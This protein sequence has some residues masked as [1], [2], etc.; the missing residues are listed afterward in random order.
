M[1]ILT[2]S[3]LE[4]RVL[5]KETHFI[6]VNRENGGSSLKAF[7]NIVCIVAGTGILG[8]PTAL[9]QGGWIGLF[10]IFL[11]WWMSS[12]TSIILIR[13]LYTNQKYRMN[14]YKDVA[15]AAFGT[16]GE[17][18]SFAGNSVL[19][20]GIPVLYIVLGGNNLNE[21]CRGTVGE[22][23]TL[24]W[25][26]VCCGIVAIPILRFKSLKEMSLLTSVGFINIVAVSIIVLV[27]ACLD[28]PNQVD[29]HRE[30]V[31]WDMFPIAFSTIAFSFGGNVIY[32]HMEASMKKP[33]D[34]P[35][36]TLFG[37]GT[38]VVLYLIVA[39][40]G[41]Q[42]YGDK[43]LS[44]VYNSIPVGVP[45][46]IILVIIIINA[47]ICA[48]F[49][50]ISLS[51]DIEEMCDITVERLGKYREFVTRTLLRIVI[52]VIVGVIACTIPNFGALMALMGALTNCTLVFIFPIAFYLKLT[53]LR[54][55]PFYELAWCTFIVILGIIGLIF[56]TKSSIEELIN[57]I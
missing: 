41:Y 56:G 2:A 11:T 4:E 18:V 40:A 23:G 24:P 5:D 26:L 17:W 37:M 46:T 19:L 48:P 45:H 20:I 44:P 36:V 57:G 47:L 53:G 42:V 7:F 28:S 13:C 27:M 52:L 8:L 15:K 1:S 16:L 38:C 10:I 54:N 32:P 31:I 39:I 34:W 12:Y 29:V 51:L 50:M 43:V 22:I 49:L 55:K 30:P 35:K 21:L 9:K 25:T 6:D 33:E 3:T 14:T